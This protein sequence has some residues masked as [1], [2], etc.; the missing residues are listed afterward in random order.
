MSKVAD[1]IRNQFP[2]ESEAAIALL[3]DLISQLDQLMIQ[4]KKVEQEIAQVI[5]NA[6][7]SALSQRAAGGLEGIYESEAF[8][9]ILERF[10]DEANADKAQ[11]ATHIILLIEYLVQDRDYLAVALPLVEIKLKRLV[12]M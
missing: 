11:V 2:N 5:T 4:P 7:L 8:T 12:V 6:V 10:P 3:C 1:G 9:G